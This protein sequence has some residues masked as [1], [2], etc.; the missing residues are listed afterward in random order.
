MKLTPPHIGMRT[1]KTTVAVM[2]SIIIFPLL[3]LASKK[4]PENSA[5]I[6]SLLRFLLN[7]DSP[8]FACIASIIVMQ[9]TVEKSLKQGSSRIVG[10]IVGG[11]VG[12][13]FTFVCTFL[14]YRLLHFALIGIG[15]V[16]VITF[17]NVIGSPK[18]TSI[19][20]VTFLIIMINITNNT[21]IIYAINRII[22][23]AIG[24]VISVFINKY[25]TAPKWLDKYIKEKR[26]SCKHKNSKDLQ[27]NNHH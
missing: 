9:P 16:A 3:T 8:I 2:L 11:I 7:R 21:P 6:L 14:P 12:L 27:Q 24:V 23:T 22:D 19:G 20:L 18:S 26:K 15:I 5:S 4:I 17:F 25:L 10:T 13:I 1:V